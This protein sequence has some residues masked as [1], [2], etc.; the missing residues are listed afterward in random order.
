MPLL[1]NRS[2]T[3]ML[4][5]VM[6]CTLSTGMFA[7][8]GDTKP[9]TAAVD[10]L[11]DAWNRKDAAGFAAA[12]TE[13]GDF[14]ETRGTLIHGRTEIGTA[15]GKLFKQSRAAAHAARDKT[16]VKMVKP[17]VALVLAKLTVKT[18]TAESGAA[19]ATLVMINSGGKWRISALEIATKA[20]SPG[21]K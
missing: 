17:D 18:G 14:I 12:F 9:I 3:A 13:D 4:A 10:R 11:L 5:V 6:V 20:A 1:T 19:L 2:L 16:Q 15:V 7:A 21:S 8:G